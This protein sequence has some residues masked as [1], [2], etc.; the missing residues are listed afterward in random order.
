MFIVRSQSVGPTVSDRSGSPKKQIR[1]GSTITSA[2]ASKT[3][4]KTPVQTPT[5]SAPDGRRARPS[6]YFF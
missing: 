3:H 2:N 5:I 6:K 4:R 1:S